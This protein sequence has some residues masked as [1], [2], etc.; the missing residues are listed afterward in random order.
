MANSGSLWTSDEDEQV[1]IFY[2]KYNMNISEIAKIHKRSTEA[3]RLRLIKHNLI[4][5]G[6]FI[7]A[8][9][10]DLEKSKRANGIYEN[11][12]VLLS[13]IISKH[14]TEINQRID[15]LELKIN[16]LIDKT[17]IPNLIDF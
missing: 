4:K 7:K 14:F 2:T 1:K 8:E 15:N 10:V 13:E 5:D 9:I 6:N 11:G 12:I 16:S 3:I 17:E